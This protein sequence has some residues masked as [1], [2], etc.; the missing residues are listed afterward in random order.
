LGVA[1]IFVVIFEH[2]Y[3]LLLLYEF[4]YMLKALTQT[5]SLTCIVTATQGQG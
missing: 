3:Y 4:T 2:L 5:I 1:H